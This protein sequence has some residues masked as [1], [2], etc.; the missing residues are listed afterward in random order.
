MKLNL[1]FPSYKMKI[2][3]FIF[4]ITKIYLCK[5]VFHFLFSKNNLS[6]TLILK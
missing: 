6:N 1:E 2:E 3:N 4:K 5:Q